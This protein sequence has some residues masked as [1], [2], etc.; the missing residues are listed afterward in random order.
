MTGAACT[1]EALE[2]RFW[3][4][5]NHV[6][7]DRIYV[8]QVK[9]GRPAA[10]PAGAAGEPLPVGLRVPDRADV[11]FSPY[12]K[13]GGMIDISGMIPGLPIRCPY[14]KKWFTLP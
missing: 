9:P 1:I 5:G 6:S 8:F 12:A 4:D 10:P 2:F 11:I 14:T 13:E 7:L 3:P